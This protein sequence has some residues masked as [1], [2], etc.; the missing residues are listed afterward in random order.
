MQW[1]SRAAG[2][3]ERARQGYS[4]RVQWL[5]TVTF[6]QAI[7]SESAWFAKS[8]SFEKGV[9]DGNEAQTSLVLDRI[10]NFPRNRDSTQSYVLGMFCLLSCGR[11]EW[12]LH[13]LGMEP[14]NPSPSEWSNSITNRSQ[15]QTDHSESMQ[16]L[17]HRQTRWGSFRGKCIE[18]AW[19]RTEALYSDDAMWFLRQENLV[20]RRRSMSRLFDVLSQEMHHQM[21]KFNDLRSSGCGNGCLSSDAFSGISSHRCRLWCWSG[22]FRG[23]WWG[24]LAPLSIWN[25]SPDWLPF[26]AAS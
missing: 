24:W 25:G 7:H 19:F 18:T 5:H 8:V 2:L 22:W 10:I 17:Q 13:Q 23:R 26:A 11:E 6:H 16:I 20:E 4:R 12:P 1:R 9:A 3:S 14:R 21:S 15:F